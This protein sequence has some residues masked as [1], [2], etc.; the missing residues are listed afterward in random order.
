[1]RTSEPRFRWLS[2]RL[3]PA[4]RHRIVS[5]TGA[6]QT[7]KTTLAQRL[8]PGLAYLNLDSIEDREVAR[9]LRTALWGTEIG[10]AV[11]DEAHK[12]PGVFEKVKFAYDEGSLPFSVLL[13]S[14][15]F[16]LL[17]RVQETLAGRVF[18]YELWPLTLSELRATADEPPP[19][20]L[21]DRLI[22]ESGSFG[23]ILAAES[24][25]LLSDK[26]APRAAAFDHLAR[27]GGMPRLLSLS[28]RDRR[29]W[30]R[31]YQQTW[32]ERDLA[33]L[34]R[35]SD[36]LPFRKLQRL[37]MLRTGQQ[38]H[39]AELGRDAEVS[40]AT[41]RRYLEFLQISFQV[42]V[43]PPYSENLTSATVKTPKLFWMDV[44][45][46][47]QVMGT[48]GELT[49]ALFETLVVAEAHKWI[50]TLDRDADLSFYRTRS[51]REV[52]LLVSTP[53][54]VLGIEVKSRKKVS[55]RDLSG[56]HA[57]ADALGERWIGG[58]V[59]HRGEDLAE[60]EPGLWGV[61]AHRLF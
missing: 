31:S 11:I 59:V 46:L 54:G 43:L 6:R 30:L 3:P 24:P 41:V 9:T 16:L 61:P 20:P 34:T 42:I 4:D 18:L 47:H 51:G 40:T 2:T 15:R 38:L 33:D 45:L 23:E 28:D 27:W 44:G 13:G 55:R 29:V 53:D 19:L 10:P 7:G 37:A 60:L 58:L 22:T 21:F 48:R 56:L 32:L 36:L 1:M 12:E 17:K 35:T 8:Y 14:S 26:A 57:L 52:D 25:R 50:A 49:G 5:V 39:Y